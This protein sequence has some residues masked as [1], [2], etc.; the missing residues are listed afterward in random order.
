LG[1][2]FFLG[3]ALSI[4]FLRGLFSFGPLHFW[5]IGLVGTAG[6]LSILL[7]ESAKVRMFSKNQR[8]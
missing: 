1:T 5:E 3:L 8:Y 2:L 6:L 4:P 7:A